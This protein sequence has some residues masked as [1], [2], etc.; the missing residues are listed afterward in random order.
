MPDADASKLPGLKELVGSLSDRVYIAIKGA[1]L[2]LEFPPGVTIRKPDFCEALN[3]SRSPVSEALARLAG[4]GLVDIIPQSG[5]TVSRLSMTAIREDTF[6]REALEVAAARHAAEHRS[7]DVLAR[8]KRNFE[9]QKLLMIDVDRDDF[10]STDTDMHDIIMSTTGVARLPATVASV[11][12]HVIRARLMMVPEP[13][14]LSETVEEHRTIIT[15]IERQDACAAA[16][17]MRH[18][19]TALLKRLQI[20][21]TDRPDLVSS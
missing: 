10:L 5:T 16:D 21:E 4:E 18:H 2:S 7:L 17:A 1:I 9:M 3:V 13:G 11:S 12:T 20:L 14:R 15:A 19:V 6:L 8:L